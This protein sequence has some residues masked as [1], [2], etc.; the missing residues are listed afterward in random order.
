MGLPIQMIAVGGVI[1]VTPASGVMWLMGRREPP[2]AQGLPGIW[3]I[4]GIFTDE[5]LAKQN[6]LDE[7]Y[8]IGP[9]PINVALPHE[10]IEWPGCYFPLR[11]SS[12]KS[13]DS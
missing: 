9:L 1:I 5:E 12:E 2:A 3:H 6:C 13:E 4:Q 11:E 10:R 8:F 7:N